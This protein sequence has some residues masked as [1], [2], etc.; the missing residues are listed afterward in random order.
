MHKSFGLSVDKNTGTTEIRKAL[1]D[2][3]MQTNQTQMI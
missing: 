1:R 3:R 2:E